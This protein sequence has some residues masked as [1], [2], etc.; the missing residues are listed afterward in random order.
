MTATL[1]NCFLLLF[2]FS[3]SIEIFCYIKNKK[4][5]NTFLRRK[6]KNARRDDDKCVHTAPHDE[7]KIKLGKCATPLK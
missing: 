3:F 6:I 2:C 7:N 1:H 5:I 4:K